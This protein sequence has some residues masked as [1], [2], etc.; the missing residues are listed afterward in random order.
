MEWRHV[1]AKEKIVD[2]LK[3]PYL[4]TNWPKSVT[5]NEINPSKTVSQSFEINFS[6]YYKYTK[7]IM[8]VIVEIFVL[9]SVYLLMC[10]KSE[11]DV[12]KLELEGNEKESIVKIVPYPYLQ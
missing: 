5:V 11:S 7:Y 8:L 10:R 1:K 12:P 4:Q 9:I 3:N 2:I 6:D